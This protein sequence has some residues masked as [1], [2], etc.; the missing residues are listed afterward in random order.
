MSNTALDQ[1]TAASSGTTSTSTSMA[2]LVGKPLRVLYLK[3]SAEEPSVYTLANVDRASETH[4]SGP[5]LQRDCAIRHFRV[6]RVVEVQTLTKHERT[7]VRKFVA[8]RPEPPAP[9]A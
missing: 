3:S 6:D 9:A 5:V 4:F 1:T 8:A 7:K 2:S